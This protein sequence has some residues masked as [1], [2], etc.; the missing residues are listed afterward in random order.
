MLCYFLNGLLPNGQILILCK[1][2]GAFFY[3]SLLIP[4]SLRSWLFS[5]RFL[6]GH[7]MTREC[8]T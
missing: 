7:A 3:R 6:T 4:F 2:C 8:S 1:S 5:N